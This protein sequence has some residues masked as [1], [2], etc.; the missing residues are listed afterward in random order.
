VL[1]DMGNAADMQTLITALGYK[2]VLKGE[3]THGMIPDT[4]GVESERRQMFFCA[5]VNLPTCYVKTD[6]R[7]RFLKN[8]VSRISHTRKSRRYPGYTRIRI[9]DYKQ[10]LVNTL[11]KDGSDLIEDLRLHAALADLQGRIHSPD[12]RSACGRLVKGILDSR[13]KTNPMDY[14]G[15]TFNRYAE[16]YYQETLRK[17][18]MAEGFKILISEFSGMDLWAGFREPVF[19]D[20]IGTILPDTDLDHFLSQVKNPLMAHDLPVEQIKKLL[21]LI[22]LYVNIEAGHAAPR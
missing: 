16:Q 6:T 22:M 2:Y 13:K 18:H 4:P 14:S 11:K 15:E 21:F 1:A 8:I 17:Q 12:T 10:A 19:K 9:K 20:I 7:N 3:V 5:A